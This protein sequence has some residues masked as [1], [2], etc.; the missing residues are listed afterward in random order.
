M[1]LKKKLLPFNP[2]AHDHLIAAGYKWEQYACSLEDDGD[3]ENGPH[4]VGGP[5]HDM[6]LSDDEYVVVTET[7]EASRDLEAPK[8]DAAFEKFCSENDDEGR[9]SRAYYG[10]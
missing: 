3:A 10:E 6:Y 1:S 5:A 4:L 2:A 8:V 7:G 9:E